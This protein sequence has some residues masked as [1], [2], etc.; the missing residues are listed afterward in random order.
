MRNLIGAGA[1]AAAAIFS[2][3]T[4]AAAQSTSVSCGGTYVIKRGDTLQRV[5]N[6]AYGPDQS[7][8][9]LYSANRDVV[10]PNPSLIEVGMVIN[11]PCRDDVAASTAPASTVTRPVQTAAVT[12]VA[13]S[14]QLRM[15]TGTDWAPFSDQDDP[16]GGMITEM[17]NVSA[18]LVYAEED[19]KI[20]FINDWSAHLQPLIADVAYH[21][22]FPWF[23]PNCDVIEKLGDDSQ[24]RCNNLVWSE[25]LFEQIMS[26]YM[27][28]DEA[29]KPQTHDGLF[30]RRLCRPAGY[31]TFMTEEKDLVEPNITL[32]RPVSPLAC[33][34]ML[35]AGEVDVVVLAGLVGDDAIAKLANPALVEEQ[36]PLATVSTLHAA[37]SINNP[38]K[39]VQLA[40]LNEGIRKIREN[41]QWFEIV[42]RHLVAHAR[43]T[44]TN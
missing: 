14:G 18:S 5:T 1:I 7:Y 6:A 38:E 41:G 39:D 33:F 27:R 24:F 29:N 20:D 37:T 42:Q 2:A 30:G 44:A 21:F 8:Q 22:T 11:V 10:G 32:V 31:A 26:Y 17:V 9:F 3:P 40:L 25:P 36:P 4:L 23:R 16:Q 12:P 28:A 19:Y 34:E 15:M 13:R 43:K 35:I